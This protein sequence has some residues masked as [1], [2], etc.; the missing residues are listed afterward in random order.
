VTHNFRP[1]IGTQPSTY[2]ILTWPAWSNAP[3]IW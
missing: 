2:F 1:L 3:C